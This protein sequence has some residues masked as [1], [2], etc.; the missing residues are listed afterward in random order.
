MGI[1]LAAAEVTPQKTGLKIFALIILVVCVIPRV[2]Q[3]AG[4]LP[5][6]T[7]CSTL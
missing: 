4:H 3:Q 7:W 2:S 5:V 1:Q 6:I